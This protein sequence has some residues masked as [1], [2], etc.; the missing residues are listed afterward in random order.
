MHAQHVAD[1]ARGEDHL[2]RGLNEGHFGMKGFDLLNDENP[3]FA[4][5]P[6]AGS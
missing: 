3:L 5:P 4:P 2:G 1:R 6:F